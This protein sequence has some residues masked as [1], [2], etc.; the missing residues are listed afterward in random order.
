ML[1]LFIQTVA[2]DSSALTIPSLTDR[3]NF[4]LTIIVLLL[5]VMFFLR[6]KA[7][8]MRNDAAGSNHAGAK[9]KKGPAD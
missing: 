1:L 9:G 6:L 2:Q 7:Y 4:T 3:L 8:T 5:I